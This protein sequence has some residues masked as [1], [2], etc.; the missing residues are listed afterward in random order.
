MSRFKRVLITGATG[1][2]GQ[3]LS[4]ELVNESYEVIAL[5]RRPGKAEELFGG[6]VE[7]VQWDARTPSGWA[8]VADGV[9]AIVN[10]AGEN[11]GQGIWT[12]RKKRRILE[13]RINAAEAVAAVV[14]EAKSKPQT[15]IQASA[16]GYYGNRGGEILCENSSAGT[17]FL[18][19]VCQQ[20][21][22]ALQPI[23]PL[24]VRVATVRLSAV[25]GI[26]G[27]LIP[28][29]LPAFRFFLGAYPGSG[30]QWLSWIHIDDV[31]G[32]ICFLMENSD[33][34]GVFNFAAPN[35]VL[36]RDFYRL[37]GK[38]AHRPVLF[39]LPAPVL[40]LLMGEMATELVLSSQRVAPKRLL[41][42]GYRFRYADAESA[43]ENII[44]SIR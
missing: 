39:S 7:V 2:V 32:A 9:L 10:L 36:S 16:I 25:L 29:V 12:Q 44:M 37:L 27:G 8:S 6:H 40:K 17:G 34:Q 3:A 33:L 22:Q 18:A 15:I 26:G 42:V 38:V 1:F 31:V 4:R 21:E 13:S 11:I 20:W 41:Q 30:S 5:S 14:A 23:V 28:R 43:L 35:P 24:G 19:G